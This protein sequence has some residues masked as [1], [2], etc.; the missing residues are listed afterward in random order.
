MITHE[1]AIDIILSWVFWDLFV[2][3]IMNVTDLTISTETILII[4]DLFYG[5]LLHIWLMLSIF[6]NYTSS[7]LFVGTSGLLVT[8]GDHDRPH[9]ESVWNTFTFRP[10]GVV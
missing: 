5:M 4:L 1:G 6:E 7:K 9:I 3:V 8:N 2:L 10:K